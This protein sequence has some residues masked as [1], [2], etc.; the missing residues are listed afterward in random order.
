L[1]GAEK[2]HLTSRRDHSASKDV[3]V[4]CPAGKAVISGGADIESSLDDDQ[5]L[6]LQETYPASTTS[7][8]VRVVRIGQCA[9]DCSTHNWQVTGW[10]ICVDEIHH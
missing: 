10:A 7:W 9:D 6:A 1:L 5:L 4:Q 3:T 8:H 2:I